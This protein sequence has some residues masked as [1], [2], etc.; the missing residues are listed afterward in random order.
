MARNALTLAR[1]AAQPQGG[2]VA[3]QLLQFKRVP[4]SANHSWHLG[5]ASQ[6][7]TAARR[8]CV[9]CPPDTA[10]ISQARQPESQAGTLSTLADL[11]CSN[12]PRC[13]PA[14]RTMVAAWAPYPARTSIP[15]PGS[16]GIAAR[17]CLTMLA[18]LHRLTAADNAAL[19]AVGECLIVFHVRPMSSRMSRA[20]TNQQPILRAVATTAGVGPATRCRSESMT[21]PREAMAPAYASS[22]SSC[23]THRSH[24]AQAQALMGKQ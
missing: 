17:N 11:A 14:S 6:A 1:V 12:E 7:G 16:K 15:L 20:G 24:H 23:S 22:I 21:V 10:E 18:T 9:H 3:A 5:S 13:G 4:P 19:T 2:L 8:A